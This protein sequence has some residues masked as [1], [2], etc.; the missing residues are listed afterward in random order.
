MNFEFLNEKENMEINSFILSLE[1][2][3]SVKVDFEVITYKSRED[4]N[5]FFKINSPEWLVGKTTDGKIHLLSR[6]I[7]EKIPNKNFLKIVKHEIVHIFIN[8]SFVKV[9]IWFNEGLACLLAG[10]H[11]NDSS[12]DVNPCDLITKEQFNNDEKAYEKSK[13]LVKI[14][15]EGV[16]DETRNNKL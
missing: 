10:Q 4:F 6:E 1:K 11:R 8:K 13:K 7:I 3:F 5:Q 14:F 2:I 16:F 9:P 12:L 15:L